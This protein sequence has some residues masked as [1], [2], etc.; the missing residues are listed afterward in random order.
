MQPNRCVPS[1]QSIAR[2][3]AEVS[4][5]VSASK[6]GIYELLSKGKP[7]DPKL[8]QSAVLHA[9]GKKI[10]GWQKSF[11]FCTDSQEFRQL[12]TDIV[13]KVSDYENWIRKKTGS[14]PAKKRMEILGI[15]SAEKLFEK[16]TGRA[17]SRV[18]PSP[19]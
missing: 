17:Q 4:K 7:L 15:P 6:K 14:L 13:R 2:L 12:D 18:M 9:L 1:K 3:S 10:Y 16:D 5:T 8:P 19:S 11:A